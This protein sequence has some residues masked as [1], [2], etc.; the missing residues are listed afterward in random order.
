MIKNAPTGAVAAALVLLVS[1]GAPQKSNAQATTDRFESRGVSSEDAFVSTGDVFS[2]QGMTTDF[3]R[4]WKRHHKGDPDAYFAS[5]RR[6]MKKA[7][8]LTPH[9]VMADAFAERNEDDYDSSRYSD[10]NDAFGSRRIPYQKLSLGCTWPAN[11][12]PLRIY[13]SGDIE[14][15]RDGRIRELMKSAFYEWARSSNGRV[16]FVICNDF[17]QADIVVC[18]EFTSDHEWAEALTE[19]HKNHLDKVKIRFINTALNPFKLS[20]GRLQAICLHE[21]GHAL[22]VTGHSSDPHDVMSTSSCDDFHPITHLTAKD[23]SMLQQVYSGAPVV[24]SR[25]LSYAGD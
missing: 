1:L 17:R 25:H 7:Y 10:G 19:F 15:A 2:S 22:G 12:M 20:D 5:R 23:R 8:T 21:V 13:F 6:A 11:R 18:E 3:R 14:Y 24:D 16:R 4:E 9:P